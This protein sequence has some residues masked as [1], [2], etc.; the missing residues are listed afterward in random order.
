M[1]AAGIRAAR[2][3][4]AI[5]V[6]RFADLLGVTDRTVRSWEAGRYQVPTGVADEVRL[7]LDR[8]DQHV[9]NLVEQ[10]T[11]C[12]GGEIAVYRN[13]ADYHAARPEATMPASWHRVIAQR[14]ARVVPGV[15]IVFAPAGPIA[16]AQEIPWTLEADLTAGA[17]QVWV[18]D[19][20]PGQLQPGIK[21]GAYAAVSGLGTKAEAPEWMRGLLSDLTLAGITASLRT[22]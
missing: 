9:A 11:G 3:Y 16:Q 7:M 19:A 20:L 6:E 15:R 14:A 13:D 2:E 5:N 4:L 22:R 1:N 12:G 17:L 21:D 8:A 18:A 10:M